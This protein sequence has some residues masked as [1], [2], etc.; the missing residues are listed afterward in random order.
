MKSISLRGYSPKS[1]IEGNVKKLVHGWGTFG[2]LFED[3]ELLV[4]G[5]RSAGKSKVLEVCL[6]WDVLYLIYKDDPS[7]LHRL[8]LQS[9]QEDQIIPLPEGEVQEISTS[10]V[11]LLVLMKVGNLWRYT[12]EWECVLG[13]ESN[14]KDILGK[15]CIVQIACGVCHHC[16]L[17]NGGVV[18]CWGCNLHNECGFTSKE[19]IVAPRFVSAMGGL[20]VTSVSAGLHHT[21]AST[22][23]GDVYSWGSNADGQLGL[24]QSSPLPTLIEA[25]ILEDQIIVKVKKFV[26]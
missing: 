1:K 25:P 13:P 18:F 20:I 7:I 12:L 5:F 15:N 22:Q 9:L 4:E 23:S 3:G 16:A 24:N 6:G 21:I 10:E 8:S 26:F 2:V 11:E 17:T 19:N 14:C